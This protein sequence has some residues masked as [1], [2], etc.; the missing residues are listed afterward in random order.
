M[1]TRAI[2][3]TRRAF[4]ELVDGTLR[5]Q[6]DVDPEHR[7]DFLRMF[8]DIDTRV[9]LAPLKAAAKSAPDDRKGGELARLAGIFCSDPGFQLWLSARFPEH[10]EEAPVALVGEELAAH[11]VRTVCGVES[12]AELDHSPG[13]AELFHEEVRRPWIEKRGA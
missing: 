5:V 12:R 11:I 2:S 1:T 4:K 3:G 8:P 6:I 7:R 9:A 13:A 10:H